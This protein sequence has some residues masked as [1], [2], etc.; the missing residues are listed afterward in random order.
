[1][2]ITDE[3]DLDNLSEDS[4][5]NLLDVCC[6]SRTNTEYINKQIKILEGKKK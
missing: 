5:I 2:E 6:L 3:I 1:M 4:I